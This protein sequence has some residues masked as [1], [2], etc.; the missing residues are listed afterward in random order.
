MSLLRQSP[1]VSG[2]PIWTH[3]VGQNRVLV[4]HASYPIDTSSLPFTVTDT[5]LTR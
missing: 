4:G 2:R 3:H 1:L 5:R